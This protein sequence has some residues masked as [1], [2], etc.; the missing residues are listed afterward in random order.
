MKSLSTEIG[1]ESGIKKLSL[2]DHSLIWLYLSADSSLKTDVRE[3]TL[4]IHSGFN[5]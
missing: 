1:G 5:I 2:F 3:G 4:I